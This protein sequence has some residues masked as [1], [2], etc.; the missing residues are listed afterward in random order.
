MASALAGMRLL[1]VEDEALVS[2]MIEDFLTDMGCVV[3]STAASVSD[4]LAVI[5]NKASALDAAMLD[6]NLGGE[7]VYPVADKLAQDGVPF[8]FSTGYSTAGIPTTY[9]HIPMLAKPFAP[10]ALEAMLVSLFENAAQPA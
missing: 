5:A 9:A 1:L 3:V 7:K 6:V 8:F 10:E 2:M 4:G